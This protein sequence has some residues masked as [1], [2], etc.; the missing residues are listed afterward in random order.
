MVHFIRKKDVFKIKR[1]TISVH[2][3]IENVVIFMK[4][5]VLK[6]SGTC[7]RVV[8]SV[9]VNLFENMATVPNR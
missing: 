3:K 5:R 8:L 7:H 2:L 6:I 9:S 1:D 4:G